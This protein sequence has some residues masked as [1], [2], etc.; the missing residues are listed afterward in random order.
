MP[1]QRIGGAGY[2]GSV[3]DHTL[4][5]QLSQ[6][7]VTEAITRSPCVASMLIRWC[8]KEKETVGE[9]TPRYWKGS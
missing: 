9:P 2:L 3:C 8:C 4:A 7:V 1:V 6:R 5:H